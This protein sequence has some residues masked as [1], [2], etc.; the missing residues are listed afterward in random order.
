MLALVYAIKALP[1]GIKDCRIDASI[2]SMA[3][4]GA[5]QGSG[6]RRSPQLTSATKR[7]YLLY[8]LVMSS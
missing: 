4:L 7:L 3:V 2:D 6:S 8:L 1:D 5:W